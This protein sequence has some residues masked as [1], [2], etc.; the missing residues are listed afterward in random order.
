MFHEWNTAEH[1]DKAESESGKRAFTRKELVA[2]LG[3]ADEQVVRI[4]KPGASDL[5]P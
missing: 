4:R 2:L 1:I 3:Y 5:T